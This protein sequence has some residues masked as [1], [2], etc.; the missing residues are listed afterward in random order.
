VGFGAGRGGCHRLSHFAA[1]ASVHPLPGLPGFSH[2][3]PAPWILL[4]VRAPKVPP[5]RGNQPARTPG[6]PAGPRG[7]PRAPARA[8]PRG[9]V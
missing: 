2:P 7:T 4:H 8:G 5:V 6:H 1:P 3:R 9:P